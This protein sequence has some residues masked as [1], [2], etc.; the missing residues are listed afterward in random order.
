M[1]GISSEA[2]ED[3]C[4]DKSTEGRIIHFNN[5]LKFA[6]LKKDHSFMAIGGPW[7]AAIDGGNPLIDSSC[8]IQTASR[9]VLY[10]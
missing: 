6:V 3:I 8:L 4:S 7:N 2:L 10:I 1:S 9:C 5:V